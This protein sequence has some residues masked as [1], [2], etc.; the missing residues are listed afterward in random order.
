MIRDLRTLSEWRVRVVVAVLGF[1]ITTLFLAR[2][3]ATITRQEAAFSPFNVTSHLPVRCA[4]LGMPLRALRGFLGAAMLLHAASF[5]SHRP[6]TPSLTR[7]LRM[8][9]SS[10]PLNPSVPS[11][12]PMR[13]SNR[14]SHLFTMSFPELANFLGGTGKARLFWS[15]IRS[16]IDPLQFVGAEDGCLSNRVKQ[17]VR[18]S[19]HC[20]DLEGALIVEE[21]VS[22]C[23]TRKFLSEL[24][25]GAKIESVLIPAFKFQRSTLCVSTQV[26]CDRRCAFCATGK[27]GLMRNLTSAEI[28]GQV[29]QGL[30]IALREGMPPMTNVV[31]M[32]MG[33]AGRNILN[34]GAAV[35][36]LVDRDRF[37]LAASKCTVSTVGPSPEAFMQLA[38]YPGTL[39]WSLHSADD[40]IRKFL[41]PSTKHSTV[42]LRDGLMAA[43]ASR[44][45]PK[46][47]TIMIAITLIE[48]VND[49]TEDAYK[50]A[51]FVRPM[52]R[53]APKI[54]LDLIPYNDIGTGGF[55]R[56]SSQA[57]NAFQAVLREEGYFVSVRVTRGDEEASAC[58]MLSTKKRPLKTATVSSADA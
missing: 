42:E 33:D 24:A 26:G 40:S 9:S 22:A 23:G 29:Y 52:L 53:V 11:A 31:F 12:T 49:S 2:P 36:C 58:G 45:A 17:R 25:D 14:S 56:P 47:R 1:R 15:L 7:T 30:R 3:P 34:V 46:T 21:T 55:R 41:V 10:D 35:Q 16:G 54:A 28:V 27:M 38:Q 6:L 43:L 5:H 8:M 39:A 18:E 13:P 57:V 37:S 19:A 51:E 50:I 20:S 44:P 4:A 32:G 48:G